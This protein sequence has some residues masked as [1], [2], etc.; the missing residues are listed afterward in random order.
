MNPDRIPHWTSESYARLQDSARQRAE[1]LRN[2][3]VRA[4]WRSTAEAL[5]AALQRALARPA[6][7]GP[8]DSRK[9]RGSTAPGLPH[10]PRRA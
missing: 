9:A 1:Q 10:S 2:D 7:Q 5:G 3:A 4:F 8:C 6:S